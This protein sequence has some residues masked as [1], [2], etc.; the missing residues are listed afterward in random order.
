MARSKRYSMPVSE[1]VIPS[2]DAL[3]EAAGGVLV[4]DCAGVMG[5]VVYERELLGGRG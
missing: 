2:P 5:G 1:I 4:T 3:T